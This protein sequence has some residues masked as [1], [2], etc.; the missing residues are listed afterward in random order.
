MRIIAPKYF[1]ERMAPTFPIWLWNTFARACYLKGNALR[2]LHKS[3]EAIAYYNEAIELN[4]FYDVA[5]H[6]PL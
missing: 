4:P 6:Q 2:K 5:W 3:G 1:I